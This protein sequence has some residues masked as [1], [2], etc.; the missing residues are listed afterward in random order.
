M[1]VWAPHC[2]PRSVERF[3]RE[4]P[5]AREL[6]A[7]LA[8]VR[9]AEVSGRIVGTSTVAGDHLVDLHVAPGLWGRGVG[10]ALMDEAEAAG[11]ARLE[12]RAFNRRAVAFYERRGWR[13]VGAFRGTELGTPV[14]TFVYER[15]HATAAGGATRS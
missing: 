13:R 1:T 8:G 3:R 4:D 2:H 7:S 5:V 10:R 11:A 14:T 12:V 15:P 6:A 9:V